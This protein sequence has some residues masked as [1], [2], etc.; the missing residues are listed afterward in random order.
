VKTA[1]ASAILLALFAM[2]AVAQ[3]DE[4]LECPSARVTPAFRDKIAAAMLAADSPE[5]DALFAQLATVTEACAG[6]NGLA[7]DRREAYF[8]YAMARLPRDTFIVRLGQAGIAAAVVDEA[9]DFG[10]GRTNPVI[11]GA[12]DKA[13]L[14]RLNEALGAQGARAGRVSDDDWQL[15]GAYAAATSLMWQSRGKLR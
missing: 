3:S 8:T 1:L 10:P 9:L 4:L 15:I 5:S 2:P 7:A 12:L 11:T 13:Q 6:Q 14:A